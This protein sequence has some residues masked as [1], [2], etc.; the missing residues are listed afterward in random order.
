MLNE[1]FGGKRDVITCIMS[2]GITSS[3]RCFDFSPVIMSK[4]DLSDENDTH[5]GETEYVMLTLGY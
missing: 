1:F 5:K 3:F 4:E 2:F